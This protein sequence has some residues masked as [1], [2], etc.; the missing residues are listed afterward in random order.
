MASRLMGSKGRQGDTLDL[1]Y[2]GV[3]FTRKY[4]DLSVIYRQPPQ[5]YDGLAC[6]LVWLRNSART[7]MSRVVR[8]KD[9]WYIPSLSL[10]P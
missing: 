5:V 4:F 3:K 6:P 1:A 10:P 9:P 7:T 2:P 8:M